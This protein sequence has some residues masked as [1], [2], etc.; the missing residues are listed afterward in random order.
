[1]LG[2]GVPAR[3]FWQCVD[4]VI[5][6]G[7]CSPARLVLLSC[8]SCLGFSSFFRLVLAPGSSSGAPWSSLPRGLLCFA[9][10]F[11]RVGF[12]LLGAASARAALLGLCVWVWVQCCHCVGSYLFYRG[13]GVWSHC[14]SPWFCRSG[15][16]SFFTIWGLRVW[17]IGGVWSFCA[18]TCDGCLLRSKAMHRAAQMDLLMSTLPLPLLFGAVVCYCALSLPSFFGAL[19]LLLPQSA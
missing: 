1:M 19:R 7:L 8:A 2:P 12:F 13:V 14:S 17:C 16:R 9:G 4:P 3:A 18:A 15:F 5:C 6:F 11:F 10:L